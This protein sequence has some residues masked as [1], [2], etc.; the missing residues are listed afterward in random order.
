MTKNHKTAVEERDGMTPEQK[1]YITEDGKVVY[2][3]FVWNDDADDEPMSDEEFKELVDELIRHQDE[4]LPEIDLD[5]AIRDSIAAYSQ[6]QMFDYGTGEMSSVQAMADFY[7]WPI[8]S[9]N[10]A[11]KRRQLQS[12][13]GRPAGGAH[14]QTALAADKGHPSRKT[15]QGRVGKITRTRENPLNPARKRRPAKRKIHLK[16]NLKQKKSPKPRSQDG[17]VKKEMIISCRWN[18]ASSATRP[19]ESSSKARALST[20]GSGPTSSVTSG[21]T[22]RRIR[23][24]RNTTTRAIWP[25]VRPTGKSRRSAA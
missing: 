21:G 4:N 7:G 20:N 18:G 23:S 22:A 14:Q 1:K 11:G 19:I 17:S 16:P 25:I 2:G 3:P 6:I 15:S 8:V 9:P 5:Q 24:R 10:P 13:T 12:Q